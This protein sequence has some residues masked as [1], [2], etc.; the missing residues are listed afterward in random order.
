MRI[1]FAPDYCS[2]NP[3]QGLLADALADQGVQVDFLQGYRRGLPL[4]RSLRGRDFDL[5][6]LHWPEAYFPQRGDGLDWLRIARFPLDLRL[7]LR[8]RPLVLTAH[9]LFPHHYARRRRLVHAMLR[10]TY[11]MASAVFCH[12]TR[13]AERV[14]QHYGIPAV[15]L[16]VIPHGDLAVAYPPLPARDEAR[17]RLGVGDAPF[18]LVF[19]RVAPYK[20]IL[21]LLELW[22]QMPQAVDLVIVG[23]PESAA[24]GQRVRAA[25]AATPGARLIDRHLPP[26]EL[27]LWLAACNATIF[28]YRA[29]LT[30]GAACLARS[31][32]VPILIRR[33]LDTVDLG[34][35]DPLVVRYDDNP[36][37]LDHALREAMR[38]E[39][40]TSC[41][42]ALRELTAW[43]RVAADTNSVYRTLVP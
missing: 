43:K 9:N 31:L 24:F 3:Y 21:E 23:E 1:L 26:A 8:G 17:R 36:G 32:G 5:L 29:I 30:S 38:L 35:P 10:R 33:A 12:G 16:H 13:A 4:A 15:K 18:C 11:G 41:P 25:V 40:E 42:V 28:H 7:A 37:S 19:G 27:V 14:G 22:R 39:A 6:H 34:E 2:S 20:G